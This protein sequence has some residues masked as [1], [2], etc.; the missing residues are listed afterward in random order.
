M[1]Q[2]F[3]TITIEFEMGVPFDEDTVDGRYGNMGYGEFN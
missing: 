1:L 3:K 2:N